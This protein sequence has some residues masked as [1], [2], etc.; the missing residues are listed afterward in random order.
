MAS[1]KKGKKTKGKTFA[2]NQFLQ[3]TPGS[4]P[5]QPIRKSTNWADEVEEYDALDSKII[6]VVLPTAPKA[7]RDFDDITSKVPMDGPY[8]AYLTNLPYDVE[9]FEIAEF[10]K[11]LKIANMRIPKE[12]RSG[13]G[14]KLRGFGYVEFEDRESLMGALMIPDTMLKN[15]RIRIEV[16]TN[17]DNGRRGNR[18]GDR[19]GSADTG[20]DWRSSNR[21]EPMEERRGGF[22]RDRESG[23]GFNRDRESSGGSFTR[24]GMR[25][26]GSK[27]RDYGG[28][29]RDR[30]GG[31]NRDRDMG[32]ERDGGFS[33]NREQS[34]RP[35]A[36]RDGDRSSN[37]NE[38]GFSR[39]NFRDSDRSSRFD[40]DE[41]DDRRGGSGFRRHDDNERNGSFSRSSNREEGDSEVPPTESRQRPKLKLA[42]RTKP[43]DQAAVK[44]EPA[45][46]SASIFGNAKP[47][48]TA[49]RERQI[50][51]KLLREQEERL[52]ES[53]RDRERSSRDRDRERSSRD[54]S[55]DRKQ[56]VRG[57]S[58][59]RKY[60]TDNHNHTDNGDTQYSS[61]QS[62]QTR[63][64]RERID[65]SSDES[66]Q[67]KNSRSDGKSP[68]EKKST[69][70]QDGSKREEK[71]D[72]LEKEMP[73]IQEP[74]APNFQGSNKFAL[75][76]D[77]SD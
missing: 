41:R 1:G 65:T 26:A 29:N 43:L 4:V 49:E 12:D 51:E 74:E 55:G 11:H 6:N 33:R 67:S 3:E 7:S 57:G 13:E 24:E 27:D 36:W 37:T 63:P 50:E 28:F 60:E 66:Q 69:E 25:E 72:R 40:R 10:F 75:L 54:S 21:P 39:G 45:V 5:S 38:R 15:R 64:S 8:M 77:D 52:R 16:S 34:D 59:T 76:N 46:P 14:G 18:M 44:P 73:K 53:S 47:V 20:G 23:G 56:I 68:D 19:M 70:K 61:T 32:R 62:Q 31:F 71:K 42:P 2:L 30:E 58:I 48:D 17:S 22:N 35:G 9:E